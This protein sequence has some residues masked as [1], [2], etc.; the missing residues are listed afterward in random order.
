MGSSGEVGEHVPGTL[1]GGFAGGNVQAKEDLGNKG[2]NSDLL[3][4][5]RGS[6]HRRHLGTEQSQR[7]L[8]RPL[9]TEQSQSRSNRPHTEHKAR[10]AR[11]TRGR[12]A[13]AVFALG[14]A[15]SLGVLLM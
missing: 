5:V 15:E 1:R 3:G 11:V 10:A 8:R 12:R 9:G 14:S 4:T 13:T 2:Q 7:H 6:W